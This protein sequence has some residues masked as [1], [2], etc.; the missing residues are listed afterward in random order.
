MRRR[1]TIHGSLQGL[2]LRPFPAQGSLRSISARGTSLACTSIIRVDLSL[3]HLYR[4]RTSV[5]FG[6]DTGTPPPGKG[7][8]VPHPTRG[9][10]G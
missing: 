3:A 1:C 9:R 5:A 8:L 7:W 6:S 10:G 4:E 2:D